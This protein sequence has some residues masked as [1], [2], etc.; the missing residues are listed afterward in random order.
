MPKKNPIV[1]TQLSK[2][3]LVSYCRNLLF[4][5]PL[6]LSL[7]FDEGLEFHFIRFYC[8][9]TQTVRPLVLKLLERKL[10]LTYVNTNKARRIKKFQNVLL[11]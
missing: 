2:L 10:Q 3:T 8:I 11:L 7:V 4:L 1:T 5:F 6:N 9:L